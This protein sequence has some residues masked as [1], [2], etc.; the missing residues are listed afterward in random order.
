VVLAGA[1]SSDADKITAA[2]LVWLT[3]PSTGRIRKS[4]R[5]M[6]LTIRHPPNAVP[7]VSAT[8]Q[9][10]LVHTGTASDWVVPWASSRT[11]RTP[12]AFCASLAPWLNARH[13]EVT[14][15]D[16]STSGLARVVALRSPTHPDLHRPGRAKAE[17][18]RDR[19][20]HQG[21]DHPGRTPTADPAPVDRPGARLHHRGAHQPPTSAWLELDGSPRH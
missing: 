6:V 13:P 16:R 17:H 1:P 20:R 18:R 9:A 14:H 15:C 11:A 7:A 10:S 8:E 5:P 19:Q 3:K 2:E 4:R 21:A 12:T